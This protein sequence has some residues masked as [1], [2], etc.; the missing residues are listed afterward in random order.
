LTGDK[1]AKGA[2]ESS[3]SSSSGACAL[4]AL[5]ANEAAG[6]H[7]DARWRGGGM[8]GSGAHAAGGDAGRRPCARTSES[9]SGSHVWWG[10]ISTISP[11]TMLGSTPESTDWMMPGNHRVGKLADSGLVTRR[12]CELPM[13][14]RAGPL[15]L[16]KHGTP[17]LLADLDEH[18]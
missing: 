2:R 1:K 17:R 16:R 11:A 4:N 3:Y 9:G 10:R 18:L 8:A 12:L 7:N 5:A 15:Y 13:I 14:N 6:I